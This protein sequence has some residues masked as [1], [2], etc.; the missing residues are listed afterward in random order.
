MEKSSEYYPD[1]SR[2]LR[3]GYEPGPIMLQIG[4]NKSGT[5]S[6]AK[7]CKIG[8]QWGKTVHYDRGRPAEKIIKNYRRKKKLLDGLPYSYFTDIEGLQKC[9]CP[10]ESEELLRLVKDQYPHAVFLLN[11]R[12]EDEWLKS[13]LAHP[14]GKGKYPGLWLRCHP[15]G[16]GSIADAMLAHRHRHHEMVMR[17]FAG[18]PD[19]LLVFDIDKDDPDVFRR[20]AGIRITGQPLAH[21]NVR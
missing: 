18:E 6:I 16:G 21:K 15:P 7:E 20:F 13:R 14:H 10:F 9:A 5:T 2:S 12:D 17:V 11:V 19:R 3:E 8:G 1:G 4:L